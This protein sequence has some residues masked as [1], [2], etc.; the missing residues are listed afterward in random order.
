VSDPLDLLRDGAARIL[1]RPMTGV[2]AGAF[3]KYL[4]LLRKWNKAQRL[5]GSDAPAWIVQN[6]FLDS[7]LFLRVLPPDVASIV[8]LGSG[9][10]IPGIPLKIVK[11]D[12]DVRLVESRGRRASFL[13]AVIRELGLTRIAVVHGRAEEHLAELGGRF[14]A[15]VMRCAGPSEIVIGAARKIVRPG[16]LIVST[17]APLARGGA[18]GL[19]QV[20][21]VLRGSTRG[22]LV[23]ER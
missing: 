16:G 13:S 8:D 14:D 1:G 6:L 23:E 22:F 7:L 20:P 19:R 4:N 12:L 3:S 9:A 10:G 2:E 18:A 11:A 5:I 15:V 21:G 17:A